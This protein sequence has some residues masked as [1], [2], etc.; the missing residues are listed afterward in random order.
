M[1]KAIIVDD[2]IPSLEM[3][4]KELRKHAGVQ[5]CATFTDPLDALAYL[6]NTPVSLAFVDIEMPGMNGLALAGR[7]LDLQPGIS[8]VFVTAFHEYAVEAFRLNALD[9]LLKPVDEIR[10]KEALNRV[11]TRT[12]SHSPAGMTVKCFGQFGVWAGQNPV[13]FRTA[14]AKELLAFIIHCNGESIS[15]NVIIDSLWPEHDG[16]KA[17]VYFNSTLYNVK[18]ALVSGGITLPMAYKRGHYTVNLQG[19]NCD[20]VTFSATTCPV[21]GMT[22]ADAEGMEQVT[23]LYAGDY[24]EGC[25]YPWSGKRRLDLKDQYI[26]MTLC[27]ARHYRAKGQHQ[28]VINK[29]KE[30]LEH[31]PLNPELNSTLVEALIITGR[32]SSAE[33]YYALFATETE[34]YYGVKPAVTYKA[35]LNRHRR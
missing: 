19:V 12:A 22:D 7:M 11:D 5:V 21:R 6:R 15:R 3:L 8:V 28:Q 16:D 18:K 31:E 33:D 13:A 24:L 20:W 9:Y 2:E 32:E 34:K 35:L 25:D 14:K 26:S 27:L 30:A 17:L 23:A 4:H 1:I 10:L 29:M